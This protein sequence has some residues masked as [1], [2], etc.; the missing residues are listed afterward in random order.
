MRNCTALLLALLVSACASEP[1]KRIELE[2]SCQVPET[3]VQGSTMSL[4][5][6]NLGHGRNTAWHQVFVST[7]RTYENLDRI[8]ALLIETGADVVALQEADAPSRWSGRFHHVEYL[9]GRSSYECSLSGHH[10][11]SW[12]YTYGTAL[13]SRAQ[14]HRSESI[15]FPSS[16]PT[17]NKGFVVTTVYWDN[18][19]SVVPVTLVSVHLD[20]SR[21]SV[22]DKQAAILIATLRTVD[23]PVVMMGDINSGWDQQRSHV[24]QLAEGLELLAYDPGSDTLGTYKKPDGKRLDWI[25]ASKDLEFVDYRVLPDQLSDHLAVYAEVRMAGMTQ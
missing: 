10:A 4:L 22:R 1:M 8:A 6:L 16:P 14:M 24:R 18:G 11:S 19:H 13:L 9:R 2:G 12:L 3:L 17:L 23:T 20:F 7:E 15:V 25:L 5:T 21:K